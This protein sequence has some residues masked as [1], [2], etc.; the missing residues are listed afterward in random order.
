M[1]E[2]FKA[3]YDREHW[4]KGKGSGTGSDATYSAKYLEWLSSTINQRPYCGSGAA[5][6]ILD[7]GCGDWQLYESFQWPNHVQYTGVDVVP[8]LIE[9]N[10]LFHAR[11]NINF[12]CRDFNNAVVLRALL[13]QVK[14]HLVLVKDV[15]QHWSDEEVANWLEAMQSSPHWSMVVATNNW[16]H[17]RTPDKNRLPRDVNNRYRWAPIDMREY[18]FKELFY[19]PRGKFKQ[20]A[21]LVNTRRG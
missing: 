18:G 1:Q 7:C 4:G 16:K 5:M 2:A 12:M 6:R 10:T 21:M 8:S 15:L 9:M 20:V 3:I 14:P 13:A 17:F 19:Y 11:D